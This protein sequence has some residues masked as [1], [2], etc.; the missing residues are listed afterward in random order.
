MSVSP[1]QPVA[2][3]TSPRPTSLDETDRKWKGLLSALVAGDSLSAA[4]TAWA[5]DLIMQGERTP[6]QIAG[7]LVALRAKGESADE[8]RGLADAMLAN[9]QPISVDG[10]TLDIV[11]TGGDGL[12]TVNISTMSS[13]VA[14]GAGITV[15]KHG[16]RGASSSAGAAD[17]IEALG[18]NLKLTPEQVAQSAREA[19]I[20]FCFA[21]V[22]HPSM[23]HAA[24]PRRELEIPTAFNILGPLTN[25]ARVRANM[26]GCANERMA[27][28]L[29]EVLAARS[30]HGFVVRGVDGRDKITTSGGTTVWDVSGARVSVHEI[31]PTDFGL[32]VVS[33]D[34]LRGK[35][36][37]HNAGIVRDFLA[38]KPGPV[39]DAVLL[40]AG[41]GIAAARY[42]AVDPGEQP[43]LLE[44]LREGFAAAQEAVDNGS[45]QAALNRWID[46]SQ[47]V[48]G[49]RD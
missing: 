43:P 21:Q 32:D 29:A 46:F 10:V 3:S 19:G 4:D 2:P 35:D 42:S 47:R 40:N 41:A 8:I 25:P 24:V 22:F 17:V 45:A 18:V 36:A 12:E 33:V 7:L 1:D 14:A 15:V 11:G 26:I 34:A 39:R 23:R 5:M 31:S 9:A 16:N 37:V 13:L 27:P 44:R 30:S 49:P 38:G 6:V 28:L 20:T 48:S